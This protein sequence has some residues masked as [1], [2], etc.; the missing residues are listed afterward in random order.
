MY[1][2][3]KTRNN[4]LN[5]YS[6]LPNPERIYIFKKDQMKSIPEE[7]RILQASSTLGSVLECKEEVLGGYAVNSRKYKTDRGLWSTLYDYHLLASNSN[8]NNS[9]R[10]QEEHRRILEEYY[11]KAISCS[12][13]NHKILNMRVPHLDLERIDGYGWDRNVDETFIEGE[14]H[15]YTLSMSKYNR[16][17]FMYPILN[18]PESLYLLEKFLE[19]FECDPLFLQQHYYSYLEM[20]FSLCDLTGPIETY[21]M[22][23]INRISGL[24]KI[25]KHCGASISNILNNTIYNDE[26]VLKLVRKTRKPNS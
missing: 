17:G 12:L 18:V 19:N 9:Q 4:G 21:D 1:L 24:L 13:F 22:E 8:Y 25:E 7:E 10:V 2:H 20:F 26:N 11:R 16:N 14:K 5:I 6:F 3:E 15:I 23:F